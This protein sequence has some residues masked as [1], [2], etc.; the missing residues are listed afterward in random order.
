MHSLMPSSNSIKLQISPPPSIFSNNFSAAHRM[1]PL[2][3]ISEHISTLRTVESHLAGM[4]YS[5]EDKVLSFILLNSLPNTLEWEMFKSSVVKTVEESELTF[6][7]IETQITSEDSRL[8]PSGHSELA[9]KASQA[10]SFKPLA[11]LL[12]ANAWCEHHL[13][14]THNSSDCNTYKRWVSE[15]RKGGFR[16]LE[17]GKDNV[18][19]CLLYCGIFLLS[20]FR[21]THIL[22]GMCSYNWVHCLILL[23]PF[24]SS[25]FE[26]W[27]H[28]VILPYYRKGLYLVTHSCLLC[29]SLSTDSIAF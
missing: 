26:L 1:G 20:F 12:S 17:K 25:F 23:G 3:H 8:Y 7:S 10:K 19:I 4:K 27:S 5:V 28:A 15:L 11:C 6:D 2:L 18:T 24:N 29:W 14:A 21:R 9:M 13:S 22:F 16:K